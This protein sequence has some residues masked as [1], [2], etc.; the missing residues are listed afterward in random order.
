MIHIT[1]GELVFTHATIPSHKEVEVE[2]DRTESDPWAGARS[3]GLQ[4]QEES[5]P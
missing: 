2:T 4:H 5:Y 3:E 1:G